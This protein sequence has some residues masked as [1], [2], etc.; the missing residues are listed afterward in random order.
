MESHEALEAQL[1]DH[2]SDWQG[3][4]VYADWLTEREDVRGELIALEHRKWAGTLDDVELGQVERRIA[5]LNKKHQR[6]WQIPGAPKGTLWE[7]DRGFVTGATFPCR[8]DTV[9][10]LQA[11]LDHPRALFLTRLRLRFDTDDDEDE[12]VWAEDHVP[13]AVDPALLKRAIEVD[14][15]ALREL[16]FAYTVLGDAGGVAVAASDLHGLTTLD[17]RY[18]FLG[19]DAMVA[20]TSTPQLGGLTELHLQHNRFG[21]AGARAIAT[22]KHLAELAVLDLRGNAIGAEGA[23]ALARSENLRTLRSLF[24]QRADIDEAGALALC[25]SPHLPMNIRRLWA[26]MW[27]RHA[28]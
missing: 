28:S 12:D 15:G 26:G 2:P 21:S 11:V 17:L 18:C 4:L 9:D 6:K 16:S 24:L 7:L 27:S 20:L 13:T 23:E 5:A 3:W 22:S 14:M 1:R 8:E 10:E 25:K 19:D